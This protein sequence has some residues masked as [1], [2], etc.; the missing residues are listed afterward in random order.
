MKKIQQAL[1]IAF[2]ASA[3]TLTQAAAKHLDHNALMS[4]QPSPNLT[5]SPP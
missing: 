5:S 2:I 1:A 3:P 4:L